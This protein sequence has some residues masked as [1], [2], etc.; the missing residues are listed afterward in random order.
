M[1][2][3]GSTIYTQTP[4][5]YY[6]YRNIEQP[7]LTARFSETKHKRPA[8]TRRQWCK[9]AVLTSMWEDSVAR[10]LVADGWAIQ[11]GTYWSK[12]NH[13]PQA[14]DQT[15]SVW[16]QRVSDGTS[17]RELPNISLR[18]ICPHHRPKSPLPYTLEGGTL[19]RIFAC[20]S[21]THHKKYP[22]RPSFFKRIKESPT[23]H[24]MIGL[25][26]IFIKIPPCL[27]TALLDELWIKHNMPTFSAIGPEEIV[28]LIS[29][30]HSL[31]L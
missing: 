16:F 14:G 5:S 8:E 18:F 15:S 13:K 22:P 6:F 9:H 4:L 31:F 11:L 12:R 10:F 24:L 28:K 20:V 25:D 30:D 7:S 2:I 27:Q 23:Y 17:H 19:L 1:C 26:G 3:P 21:S 29:N